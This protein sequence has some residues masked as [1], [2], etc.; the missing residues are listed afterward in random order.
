M[1]PYRVKDG[2]DYNEFY[3]L[4]ENCELIFRPIVDHFM[5]KHIHCPCDDENS[6][7]VKW[8]Q[9]N[10]DSTITYSG[11]PDVDM[12]SDEAHELMLAADMV[13]TNPPYQFN[14]WSQLMLFLIDNNI[15][16]FIFGSTIFMHAQYENRA[17]I[18]ANSYI[19]RSPLH[20]YQVFTYLHRDGTIK[21]AKTIFYS[22]MKLPNQSIKYRPS[23]KPQEYHD[24]I[25]V[26]NR[27]EN[28]PPDF[29][30]WVYVPCTFFTFYA[31]RDYDVELGDIPNKFI[32][33]KIRRRK[34]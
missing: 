11:L 9:D 33:F 16:F 1:K 24:G 2:D 15:E 31:F 23:D 32:R 29:D 8:L 30:G 19:Y 5:H 13:V 3:T 25:P 20:Q 4:Y 18:L 22:S 17:K 26:Y 7:I 6:N 14:I 27:S 12:N 34:E 10:T 28:V 21:P